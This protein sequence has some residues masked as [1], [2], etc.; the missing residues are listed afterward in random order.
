MATKEFFAKL[1]KWGESTLE[2]RRRTVKAAL[3]ERWLELTGDLRTTLTAYQEAMDVREDGGNLVFVVRDQPRIAR[4]VELGATPWDLRDTVLRGP[5]VKISRKGK[6]FVSVPFGHSTRLI[7]ARGGSAVERLA[8][9]LKPYPG[10]GHERL[11]PGMA[12]KLDPY[13]VTDPLDSLV[14][15]IRPPPE[16]GSKYM[17]WRTISE[18]GRPWIHPGIHSRHFMRRVL[19]YEVEEIAKKAL[20]DLDNG[21]LK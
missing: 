7:R 2:L 1:K 20:N 17:T 5:N 21:G 6:K 14:R 10:P 3:I 12:E 15:K 4:M 16:R 13:H 8:R 9:S 18:A 19:E 11:P